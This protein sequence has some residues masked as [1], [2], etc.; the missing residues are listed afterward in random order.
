MSAT[1][2][3]EEQVTLRLSRL[4]G[5]VV[6]AKRFVKSNA[7]DHGRADQCGANERLIG[8]SAVAAAAAGEDLPVNCGGILTVDAG[9]TIAVGD[10]VVSDANGKAVARG[11]TATVQYFVA[12]K[13]L[14]QAAAG[15]QVSVQWGPYA[16]W[17][18][19]AS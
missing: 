10:E 2:F 9:G 15:E 5:G 8:V 16:I 4:S 14:T 11:V 18:A 1:K 6:A 13:A 12:G 17:G 19:N 3:L 7:A